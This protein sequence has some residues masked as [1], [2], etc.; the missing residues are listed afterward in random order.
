MKLKLFVFL[1][2]ITA[3]PAAKAAPIGSCADQSPCV[4]WKMTKLDST[5]CTLN[6]NCPIE[7]CFIVNGGAD[8]CAKGGGSGISHTCSQADSNGCPRWEDPDAATGPIM[9]GT[10]KTEGFSG[11]NEFCQ[12]GV[13]GETLYWVLKDG[14]SPSTTEVLND[15]F[16]DEATDCQATVTCEAYLENCGGQSN[17]WAKERTWTFTIPDDCDLCS[18]A[19]VNQPVEPPV[20]SPVEPPTEPPVEPPLEPPVEPPVDSPIPESS[21]SGS[22]GDPHFKTWKNEHFEYHGQCD[23]VLSKDPEFSN[24]L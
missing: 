4:S 16:T 19:P 10:T 21:P 8:G 9:P 11:I 5:S 12:Q 2:I 23:M 14:N 15:V 24:G 1:A 22:L 20:E 6:N 7:V 18:D 3:N 17:Q 13:P